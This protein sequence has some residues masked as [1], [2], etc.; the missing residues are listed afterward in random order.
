MAPDARLDPATVL[1]RYH[2]R[3]AVRH[4]TCPVCV[5]SR[6]PRALG[7]HLARRHW[8]PAGS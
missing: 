5:G 6:P 2:A 8:H 4:L 1:A 7:R 3:H